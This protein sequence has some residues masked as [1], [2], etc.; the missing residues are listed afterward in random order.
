MYAVQLEQS[1]SIVQ[2]YTVCIT[3]EHKQL[4]CF[5]LHYYYYCSYCSNIPTSTYYIG[6]VYSTELAVYA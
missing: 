6:A 2:Q 4:Y 5:C 1:F 3:K